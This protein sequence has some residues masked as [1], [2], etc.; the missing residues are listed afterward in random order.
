MT[1]EAHD[2]LSRK[3]FAQLADDGRKDFAE[4]ADNQQ[5]E[6]TGDDWR[7]SGLLILGSTL[8][9]EV[10]QIPLPETKLANGMYAQLTNKMH[11][12]VTNKMHTPMNTHLDSL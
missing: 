5:T 11:A 2:C 9:A 1:R 12:R 10:D 7:N 6:A 8:P 3:D 4:L